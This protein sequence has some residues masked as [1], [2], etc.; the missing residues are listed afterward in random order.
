MSDHARLLS[1][2]RQVLLNVSHNEKSKMKRNLIDKYEVENTEGQG[3]ISVRQKSGYKTLFINDKI[4]F[5]EWPLGTP[6]VDFFY[7]IGELNIELRELN[8]YQKETRDLKLGDKSIVKRIASPLLHLMEVGTYEIEFYQ[9]LSEEIHYHF[10]RTQFNKNENPILKQFADKWW[11]K[12]EIEV[13]Q[14]ERVIDHPLEKKIDQYYSSWQEDYSYYLASQSIKTIDFELVEKYIKEI[15]NGSKPLI[16]VTDY[17]II[18]DG[19]HKAIAYTIT[20]SKPYILRIRNI[21][22]KMLGNKSIEEIKAVLGSD[23]FE[24]LIKDY[25]E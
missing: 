9:D 16:I 10:D 22:N 12:K 23:E 3:I 15:G 6:T 1:V 18:L 7:K 4:H 5:A 8:E 24:H 20:N 11:N 25:E 17:S 19:H 14:M 2:V 13:L 21:K